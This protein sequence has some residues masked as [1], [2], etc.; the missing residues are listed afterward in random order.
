MKELQIKDITEVSAGA[1]PLL[2]V[3]YFLGGVATGGA[4][5]AGAIWV[6]KQLKAL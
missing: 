3:G 2:L 5:A 6:A 4:A 1:G